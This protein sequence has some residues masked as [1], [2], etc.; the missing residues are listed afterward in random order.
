M[1][2]GCTHY[3]AQPLPGFEVFGAI[4]EDRAHAANAAEPVT[5]L[6][7]RARLHAQSPRIAIAR[8]RHAT[9]AARAQI[10]EPWPDPSISIGPQLA[11]GR[12][13]GNSLPSLLASLNLRIPLG[14]RLAAATDLDR[15]IAGQREVEAALVVREEELAM[16]REALLVRQT[17]AGSELRDIML[18]TAERALEVGRR[19]IEV[20][21]MTAS[22]FAALRRLLAEQH[23][24]RAT[25][26]AALANARCDLA[27][28]L[29][30]SADAIGSIAIEPM[31]PTALP[32]REDLI[33]RLA[34]N[35]PALLRKRAEY[36]V[37]EANLRLEVAQQWPDITLTPGFNDEPGEDRNVFSLG[38][39]VTLPVFD[40]NQ[41][42]IA[43]SRA[44]RDQV[45]EEYLAE[46]RIALAELDRG[47]VAATNAERNLRI[48][49]EQ[50]V[51]AAESALDAAKLGLEAG[52]T[53][54]LDVIDALRGQMRAHAA[55]LDAETAWL[56]AVSSLE[57]AIGD[58]IL[59]LE[60]ES[61]PND[62]TTPTQETGH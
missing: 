39:G 13:R 11:T 12:D 31:A 46:V 28:R 43:E 59:E 20:G 40:G 53:T 48:A 33:V 50:L 34:E 1:V 29:G 24:E 25:V 8:A 60:P 5:L 18:T 16:R 37:A 9:A 21:S 54:A 35:R 32:S 6:Q 47:L 52:A 57:F 42:N 49:R 4:D 19:A 55:V 45:R 26:T 15:V 61:E 14:D 36:A 7:L 62:S 58:A 10:D 38:L 44:R 56:T 3:T 22:G 17:S 2:G 51:P 23:F 30:C 27:A 41:K